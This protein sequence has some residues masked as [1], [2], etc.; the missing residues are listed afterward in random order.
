MPKTFSSKNFLQVPLRFSIYK[1][2]NIWSAYY[3]KSQIKIK[4]DI[5]MKKF[6]NYHAN[7]NGKDV[8]IPEDYLVTCI[9]SAI[10]YCKSQ[11]EQSDID[12]LPSIDFVDPTLTE[13]DKFKILSD[14]ATS[15]CLNMNG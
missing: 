8:T 2:K 11:F 13:A 9:R 10:S 14:F 4:G 6:N 1:S 5:R 15:L 12:W 7:I 3:G